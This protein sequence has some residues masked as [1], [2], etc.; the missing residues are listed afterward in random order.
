[1]KSLSRH[2]NESL[3]EADSK[4]RGYNKYLIERNQPDWYKEIKNKLSNL[5]ITNYIGY[6]GYSVIFDALIENADF[7]R[8]NDI[9]MEIYRGVLERSE[10]PKLIER[11]WK[12]HIDIKKIPNEVV[13]GMI[14]ESIKN[15]SKKII[16]SLHNNS[17]LFS[18][19][20]LFPEEFVKNVSCGPHHLHPETI[21]VVEW[22]V[23][24]EFT[25]YEFKTKKEL[26]DFINNDFAEL[27]LGKK[28]MKKYKSKISHDTVYNVEKHA[29]NYYHRYL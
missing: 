12:E 23:S 16:R 18:G 22:K 5:N 14:D 19:W 10:F 28:L 7:P 3:N 27:A 4:I 8:P 29:N 15:N 26:N 13:C 9:S 24:G 2:L 20:F 1:M 21:A 25:G 6:S 17:S 11:Y